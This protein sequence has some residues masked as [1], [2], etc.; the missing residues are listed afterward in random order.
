V[1]DFGITRQESKNFVRGMAA[2]RAACKQSDSTSIQVRQTYND[3]LKSIPDI[4]KFLNKSGG[5]I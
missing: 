4:E 3:Q 1:H 5:N 2:L